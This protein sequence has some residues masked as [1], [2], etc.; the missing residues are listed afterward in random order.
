MASH[1]LHSATGASDAL[2][3]SGVDEEVEYESD[4]EG[5]SALTLRRRQASDDEDDE[6]ELRTGRR[7][8][9]RGYSGNDDRTRP[10]FSDDDV[11]DE[12][13]PPADE[14]E[15]EY[16]DA[17]ENVG[18]ASRRRTINDDTPDD[19]VSGLHREDLENA[20]VKAHVGAPSQGS[21]SAGNRDGVADDKK[22]AEPFVVPTAGAFYMHDDRFQDNGGARPRRSAGGR[23]IWEAKDEKPW[24]HDRFEELNLHEESYLGQGLRGRG[25]GRLRGQ[26]RGRG[27]GKDSGVMKGRGGRGRSFENS[28]MT[29]R[30]GSGRG[31]GLRRPK[32]DDYEQKE[33]PSAMGAAVSSHEM[34]TSYNPSPQLS[35]KQ[36]TTKQKEASATKRPMS[37]SVL[38]SASPPFYPSGSLSQNLTAVVSGSRKSI[39]GADEKVTERDMHQGGR[40]DNTSRSAMEKG[41]TGLNP[42]AV[43]RQPSISGNS[44]SLTLVS[45][46]AKVETGLPRSLMRG[47]N[48]LQQQLL[49]GG[50]SSMLQQQLTKAEG[51]S[52][53]MMEQ[54]L[55]TTASQQTGRGVPLSQSTGFPRVQQP[56]TSKQGQILHQQPMQSQ[57]VGSGIA[58]SPKPAVDVKTSPLSQGNSL[59]T[60]GGTRG[61]QGTSLQAGRGSFV[62]GGGSSG[63]LTNGLRSVVQFTG[64]PQAGLGVPAVGMAL[65]GYSSQPQF[66][67]AN[68]EVTW[69]PILAGGGALGSNYSSPYIA[70]DGASSAV[71]Y[72][73]PASQPAAFSIQ[74]QEMNG[75]K[76]SSSSSWKPP[77]RSDF[78]NDE[79]GQRQSKPRR[80]SEMNFGQ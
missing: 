15:E 26:G 38:N 51:K 34:T 20:S 33:F 63:G 66:G 78:G 4:S 48:T 44:S 56:Q 40:V 70:V 9:D 13:A 65:P 47:P 2:S 64:Q 12:G 25:K 28:L 77:T 1:Q 21:R 55:V 72:T 11:E 49:K 16:E 80:Y 18:L 5:T 53:P 8:F 35:S 32:M 10:P 76:L 73:Q 52:Q 23:R 59:A 7:T 71:Y 68:S 24:V 22:D 14:E 41:I 60:S 37:G 61:G 69:V 79:F 42:A 45:N 6:R 50:S 75:A 39:Q 57:T 31:R 27:R 17:M 19:D 36:P 30:H 67:F 74:G 46:T 3:E 43:T 62:Y 29:S 54:P 58:S